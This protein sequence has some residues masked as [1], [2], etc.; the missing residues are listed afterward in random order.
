M[1]KIIYKSKGAV[2]ILKPVGISAQPD[3]TSSD[4]ALTQTS[5]ELRAAGENSTLYPV[6][7]LDKVVSGLLIF[8]RTKEYAAELSALVSG[9]GIG[10]EYFAVVEGRCSEGKMEDYLIK[11]AAL[12]KA[13]ISKKDAAGAKLAI[14]EAEPLACVAGEHGEHTLVKIKLQTGRF[15][16]I[17]AQLSARGC[18]I[19]GD[20]KYGA[21]GY[22]S[23]TPALFSYRL[24]IPLKN[25]KISARALPELS[26]YPWNLF[27]SVLYGVDEK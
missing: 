25:E 21:K 23:R 19:V 17:R 5:A 9:E 13:K 4:D 12:G 6:H 20:K 11:D 1:A 7:R 22:L 27:D 24:E 2:V 3:S 18:P 15:H 14:L 16:Q 8:A 26:E 10:K